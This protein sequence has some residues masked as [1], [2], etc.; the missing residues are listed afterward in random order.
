LAKSNLAF[1]RTF[2]KKAEE[3]SMIALSARE[4]ALAG[5]GAARIIVG[6]VLLQL[7]EVF[8]VADARAFR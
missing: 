5:V 4:A 1:A 2:P 7:D 3:V 8:E 6:L